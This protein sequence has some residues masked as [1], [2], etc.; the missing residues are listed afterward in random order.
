M[1]YLGQ[2]LPSLDALVFFEAAARLENFTK[3]AE[4]LHVSQVAVSKRIHQLEADLGTL[5]FEKIGRSIRL[6]SEGRALA[7][8]ARAGLSFLEE[9]V[10]STRRGQNRERQLV[11]IAANENVNFFWLAPL[12]REFQIAGDEAIVS[13]VSANNVTDVVR[14]ETD[15]AIFH[16]K[17]PPEGWKCE[18]LFDEIISP[19]A[20][21]G[22]N[23]EILRNPEIEVTLLDYRKESPEWVNWNSSEM[24]QASLRFAKFNRQVCPSYI[25]TISLAMKG[26]GVALGVLPMLAREIDSRLL[27]P[28]GNS[29][30]LTGYSYFLGVPEARPV[31]NAVAR[32]IAELRRAA[33]T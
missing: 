4:E 1:K 7:V 25:Q 27:V 11:Q 21:P 18:P 22:L 32:L 5:L 23:E 14:E 10:A 13:V 30:V 24:K 33:G 26:K 3:A 12:L 6:T 28:L 2:T 16:G 15:L 19:V 29:P 20:S 9:A 17:S 31:R 8:R